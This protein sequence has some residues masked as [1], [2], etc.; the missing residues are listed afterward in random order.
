M[1]LPDVITPRLLAEALA[2][3]TD[4]AVVDA[5]GPGAPTGKPTL[6]CELS[7]KPTLTSQV[8]APSLPTREAAVTLQ[9]A[10]VT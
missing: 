3:C 2:T 4:A 10:C 9:A 6:T 8:A 7:A 1:I 5:C